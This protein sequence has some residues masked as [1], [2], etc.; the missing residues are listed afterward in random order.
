MKRLWK[1]TSK[2]SYVMN[3]TQAIYRYDVRY[4]SNEVLALNKMKRYEDASKIIEKILLFDPLNPK[5][6]SS[7]AVLFAEL[8]KL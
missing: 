1:N 2:L 7:K 3:L 5:V 6:L 4:Y 8:S